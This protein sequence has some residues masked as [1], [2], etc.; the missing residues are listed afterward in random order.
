MRASLDLRVPMWIVEVD[1]VVLG[2]VLGPSAVRGSDSTSVE[3]IVLS[4]TTIYSCAIAV[5][6]KGDYR[7]W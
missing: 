7:S 1:G 4:E 3:A 6:Q 5:I 2:G